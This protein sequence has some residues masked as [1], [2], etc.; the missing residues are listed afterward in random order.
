MT[1]RCYPEIPAFE[2]TAERAVWQQ[3]HDELPHD[4]TLWANVVFTTSQGVLEADLVVMWPDV[5]V[6]VI[7]VKGGT[8]SRSHDGSW[9]QTGQDGHARS[10]S[11]A[12]QARK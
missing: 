6:A 12:N 8:V 3:L 2:S 5:G 4:A 7:E 1:A 11:P 10:I 9:I